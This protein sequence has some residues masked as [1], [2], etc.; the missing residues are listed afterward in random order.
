[1]SVG[2]I[3]SKLVNFKGSQTVVIKQNINYCLDFV[4]CLHFYKK[5]M[6]WKLDPI[7]ETVSVLEGEDGG[8]TCWIRFDISNHS[9]WTA[10]ASR[11]VPGTLDSL[12]EG[13]LDWSNICG[14]K[15]SF[16]LLKVATAIGNTKCRS[17]ET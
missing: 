16:C 3:M 12:K 10:C 1:M 17:R 15:P 7:P 9:H 4:H 2:F 11:A 8:G 5:S 13:Q 14:I 6:L